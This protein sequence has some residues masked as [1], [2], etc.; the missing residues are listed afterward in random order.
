M[1]LPIKGRAQKM[2]SIISKLDISYCLCV[3]NISVG[4]SSVF[5]DIKQVNFTLRISD[6]NEMTHF[7]EKSD[8][9]VSCLLTADPCLDLFF[10]NETVFIFWLEIS[11]RIDIRKSLVVIKLFPVEHTVWLKVFL[12]KFCLL[13]FLLLSFLG[14]NQFLLLLW[15]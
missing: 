4:A 5:H 8:T 14:F 6:Q 1:N 13:D 15:C 7:R 9:L 12:L 3:S 2:F 11:W 10:W